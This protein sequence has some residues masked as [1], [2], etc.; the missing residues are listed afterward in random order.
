MILFVRVAVIRVELCEGEIQ[1]PPEPLAFRR[2]A[3]THVQIGIAAVPAVI[4]PDRVESRA[5]FPG[6]FLKQRIHRGE[7]DN[8]EHID[9]LDSE[10]VALVIMPEADGHEFD[11]RFARVSDAG[12]EQ[13]VVG[14][15]EI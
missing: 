3:R 5:Q 8:I 7:G 6:G 12:V 14:R 15:P 13:V 2:D 10:P 1:F 4:V 9:A 11:L